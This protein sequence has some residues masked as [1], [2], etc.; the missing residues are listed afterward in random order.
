MVPGV[1]P[2]I[3]SVPFS[4]D[5]DILTGTRLILVN[6]CLIEGE[7]MSK[8]CLGEQKSIRFSHAVIKGVFPYYLTVMSAA[9]IYCL[10]NFGLLDSTDYFNR[11][12]LR[13]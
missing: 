6:H 5:S 9:S 3:N 2:Y 1:S 12:V 7:K 8:M 4:K 10:E 11:L 13:H